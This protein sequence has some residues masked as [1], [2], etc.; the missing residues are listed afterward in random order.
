MIARPNQ[1]LEAFGSRSNF[2]TVRGGEIYDPMYVEMYDAL[3]VRQGRLDYEVQEIIA[4]T[5]PTRTSRT[6]DVGSG[7]GHR[8]GMLNERGLECI[9]FEQSKAMIAKSSEEY[10][11]IQFVHGDAGAPNHNYYNQFSQILCMYFTF[12]EIKNQKQFPS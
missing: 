3:L 8:C 6:L 11:G 12:Y 10:P 9:G 4:K 7:T 1:L 5:R 2:R